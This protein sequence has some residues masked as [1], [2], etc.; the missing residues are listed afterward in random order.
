MPLALGPWKRRTT[1]T[2]RNS[3]PSLE[4]LQCVF[5]GL[6]H[7]GGGLDDAVLGL[8][9]RDL[10]DRAAQVALDQAQAAL[11]VEGVGGRAQDVEIQAF[12]DPVAPDQLAVHHRRLLEIGLD[13]LAHDGGDVLWIWPAWASS[14]AMKATPPAAWKAFTSAEPL[15]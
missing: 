14:R 10:D 6:E 13:S 5:L 12:L 8:D 4:G 2:S 15:G 11:L 9:G 3:L 1:T 7:G